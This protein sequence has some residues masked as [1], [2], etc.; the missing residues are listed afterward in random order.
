[1]IFGWLTAF[2]VLLPRLY[3]WRGATPWLLAVTSFAVFATAFTA[4]AGWHLRSHDGVVLRPD[5]QLKFSP[6]AH[7]QSVA[8]LQAGE[9][10]RSLEGNGQYYHV[11][12]ADGHQGWI[13]ADSF[14]PIWN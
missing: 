5:T 11:V 13:A 8:I 14:T 7:S 3:R 12:S 1:V 9:I 4:L 6:T 10:A 2:L